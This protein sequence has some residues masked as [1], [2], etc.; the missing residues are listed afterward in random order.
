MTNCLKCRAGFI[1]S[2]EVHLKCICMAL[3]RM[4]CVTLLWKQPVCCQRHR[5]QEASVLLPKHCFGEILPKGAPVGCWHHVWPCSPLLAT[6][7]WDSLSPHVMPAARPGSAWL[8]LI[9]PRGPSTCHQPVGSA[10]GS[11]VLLGPLESPGGRAQNVPGTWFG[12]GSLAACV[13]RV[14]GGSSTPCF[15]QCLILW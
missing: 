12:G 1:G 8:P 6:L 15:L 4:D 5:V 7:L 11:C 3:V 14:L 10:M 2:H 9:P 13:C